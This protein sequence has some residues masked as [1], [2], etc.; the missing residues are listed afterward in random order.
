MQFRIID[1][2]VLDSTN[3]YV[4]KLLNTS[5][6]EEAFIVRAQYQT[7]GKGQADKT[8]SSSKGENFLFSLLLKPKFLMPDEAFLISQTLALSITDFLETYIDNKRIRIKWPNDIYVDD[9]KIAGILIQNDI[10]THIVNTVAGIGININQLNF[11]SPIPN[12][13]SLVH[14]TQK[15]HDLHLLFEELLASVEKN[16]NFLKSGAYDEIRRTYNQKLYRLNKTAFF[17]DAEALVFKGKLKA[18]DDDG[19]LIIE[20]EGGL[21]TF[22]HGELMFVV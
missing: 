19:Q 3:D 17:K 18:V 2:E 16:Y 12:P 15:K 9:G 21:R 4:K 22:S 5:D 13:V 11:P 10:S 8:W 7:K 14:F 6:L 1:F 20:T